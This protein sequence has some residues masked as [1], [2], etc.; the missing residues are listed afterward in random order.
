MQNLECKKSMY[1]FEDTCK[2]STEEHR[3]ERVPT[4]EF[5]K[6]RTRRTTTDAGKEIEKRNESTR[7]HTNDPTRVPETSNRER[8]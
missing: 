4:Q 5:Q 7:K 1:V 8:R 3:E 6:S 2:I